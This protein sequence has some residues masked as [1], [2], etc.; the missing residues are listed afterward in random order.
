M[1]NRSSLVCK[2]IP[3]NLIRP[4]SGFLVYKMATVMYHADIQRLKRATNQ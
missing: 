2:N 3:T 4:K 1:G